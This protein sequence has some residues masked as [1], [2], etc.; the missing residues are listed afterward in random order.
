MKEDILHDACPRIGKHPAICRRTQL[1]STEEKHDRATGILLLCWQTNIF[2]TSY[3]VGSSK[4][5]C[6]EAFKSLNFKE[7]SY[8]QPLRTK[9]INP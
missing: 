6:F 9:K 2:S 5:V 1:N 8:T 7:P 3:C 4:K